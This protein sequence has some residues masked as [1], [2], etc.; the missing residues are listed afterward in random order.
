MLA[1]LSPIRLAIS[2]SERRT[3]LTPLRV[4]WHVPKTSLEEIE[5]GSGSLIKYVAVAVNAVDAFVH[6]KNNET[7]PL[8]VWDHASGILCAE[9][10]GAI[11]ND[12]KR[13]RIADRLKMGEE[14]S[15]IDPRKMFS[16][17]NNAIVVAN[18]LIMRGEILRAQA[19]R[20]HEI[21]KV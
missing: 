16:C 19:T 15:G 12:G 3:S 6:Y 13:K 20:V 1:Q 9:E 17:E 21:N 2:A 14:Y 8:N 10:A 5:Y 4:S 7:L 18:D 11:L